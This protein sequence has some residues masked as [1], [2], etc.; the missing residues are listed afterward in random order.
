MVVYHGHTLT[1]Q[2]QLKPVL[3]TIKEAAFVTSEYPIILSIEN[4]CHKLESHRTMAKLMR[5]VFD[6]LL[7]IEPIDSDRDHY[8]PL[9]TMKRKIFIKGSKGQKNTSQISHAPAAPMSS[10]DS[11]KLQQSVP[12]SPVPQ[13]E[14]RSEFDRMLRSYR[15]KRQVRRRNAQRHKGKLGLPEMRNVINDIAEEDEFEED[16]EE[17]EED[18]D[19]LSDEENNTSSAPPLRKMLRSPA[20]VGQVDASLKIEKKQKETVAF[21]FAAIINYFK[22]RKFKSIKDCLANC[23]SFIYLFCKH[24]KNIT[25]F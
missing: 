12:E 20:H 1:S 7:Y 10:T 14:R 3:E 21:E 2:L 11:A 15:L 24:F 16:D 8:P 22:T 4:N 9:N 17:E 19:E 23:K 25:I 18:D 13:I 5:D 6:D